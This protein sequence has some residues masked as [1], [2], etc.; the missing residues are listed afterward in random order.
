MG[1]LG[2]IGAALAVLLLCGASA[3]AQSNKDKKAEAAMRSVEGVVS[4]PD[5]SVAAGAVVQL[6]NM[7][8]LQV[9][10]FITQSDGVYHFYELSPD[11]D[12]ELKAELNAATSGAK[13]LSSFDSRKKAILNLKLNKK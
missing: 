3:M 5:E 11:I 13:M 12:Y 9:R 4:N 10:S 8:T 7:K 2:T 1:R 6:K